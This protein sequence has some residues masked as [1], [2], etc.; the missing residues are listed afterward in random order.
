MR[1]KFFYYLL[2]LTW[3]L[4]MTLIGA[5]VALV[6]IIT[7]HKPKKWGGCFYFIVKG[8]WGGI[9]LGLFFV[10]DSID[11]YHTKC[12]EFGH[13]IQNCYLGFFMP[14]VIGLPSLIRCWYREIR[15]RMGLENKTAYDDAWFEGWATRVGTDNIDFW[16]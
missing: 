4:P 9:N 13:S 5:L 16:E 2:S 11:G 7:G 12:H 6:L 10:T 14:F 15:D 8:Y 3:G 1:N